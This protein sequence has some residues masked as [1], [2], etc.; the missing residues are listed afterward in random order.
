MEVRLQVAHGKANVKQVRLGPETILGRG[1]SCNLRIVSNFVSRR[2]C[3]IVVDEERVLVRDLGSANGTLLD[4]QPVP[5]S[6]DLEV[7]PGARLTLGAISFVVQFTP[8]TQ[9]E[10]PRPPTAGTETVQQDKLETLPSA[11]G[12][13]P[14]RP[15]DTVYDPIED[16]DVVTTEFSSI[17]D[18]DSH[19]EMN[20][21]TLID[22]ELSAADNDEI[23]SDDDDALNN[24]L[25]KLE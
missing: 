24:F 25:E 11:T 4:G 5:K 20:R 22:P 1:S 16:E 21:E 8:A 10:A 17:S 18:P 23:G 15:D 6:E 3:R 12:N 19:D 14:P 9:T 7:Q 13:R 2:H